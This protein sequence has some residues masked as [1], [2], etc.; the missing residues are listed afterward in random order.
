MLNTNFHSNV[1]VLGRFYKQFL[2]SLYISTFFLIS[3]CII[4]CCTWTYNLWDHC[5]DTRSWIRGQIRIYEGKYG[6]LRTKRDLSRI[7]PDGK[8]PTLTYSYY[9]TC[10]NEYRYIATKYVII[11]I[12][13]APSHYMSKISFLFS[14]FFIFIN[15]SDI[16]IVLLTCTVVF[17]MVN[18][19]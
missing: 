4:F 3:F 16:H 14:L 1:I 17:D 18:I 15:R 13:S 6:Y 9:W 19:F 5:A 11:I 12:S 8:Q 10:K 2:T 7:C